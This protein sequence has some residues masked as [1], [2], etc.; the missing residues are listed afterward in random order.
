[1]CL[2]SNAALSDGRADEAPLTLAGA[3]RQAIESNLDL[4]TR[5]RA[6]DA[7]RAEVGLARAPLLPQADLGA[8]A[9][10]L[11]A[12]R[13]DDARGNNREESILLAAGLT[14]VLY[15]ENSWAG[16]T[17]R[18]HLYDADLAEFESARLAVIEE[19]A[20]AYLE[21]SRAQR[22]LEIEQNNRDLTEQN[23]EKSRAR[24]ATGWSSERE[25]LRWETQLAANDIDVR[26]A[27]IRVLQ[28][29]FDLNRIRNRPLDAE[30]TIAPATLEDYGFV[31]ASDEVTSAISD[32]PARRRLRD[33][34]VRVGLRRSPDLRALD[35]SIAG[36]ERQF[37][38]SKRVFWLPTLSLG[39]GVDYLASDSDD[40]SFNQTEW[41]VKGLLTYPLA[42][43]GGKL[44]EV[45]QARAGVGQQ[46]ARRRATSLS[47]DQSIRAAFAQATGTF[48]IIEAAHRQEEAGRRN[49]ELVEQSYTLGVA[50]ILDLLD[51]Q[52]QLL[53]A[54][55]ALADATYGFLEDVVAA[56]RTIAFYPFLESPEDVDALIT[57]LRADLASVPVLAPESDSRQG[58]DAS[59]DLSP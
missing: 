3:A 24:I 38:A 22:R 50:S 30:V 49:F 58:E 11:D 16:F 55:L 7:S 21:L 54:E 35:D 1:M 41:V 25:V 19:T 27:E 2:L 52:S 57:G 26:T 42:R 9:Q 13:S 45:D 40:A 8:R 34:F 46:R 44:A 29:A 39:A 43:G 36:A 33:Y 12:E 53:S 48:V 6:L 51:A 18:K 14:Q 59:S 17:T 10:L 4:V 47:L 20:V 28:T 15:D 37:T 23:L 32:Q 5:R 56:E 31:F